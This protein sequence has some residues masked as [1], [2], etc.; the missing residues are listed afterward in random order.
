MRPVKLVSHSKFEVVYTDAEG[1]S[2]LYDGG[3]IQEAPD[4]EQFIDYVVRRNRPIKLRVCGDMGVFPNQ[5]LVI[6]KNN[7]GECTGCVAFETEGEMLQFF[8]YE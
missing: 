6:Q 3:Y 2:E 7:A 8:E 5:Y 1:I 4:K